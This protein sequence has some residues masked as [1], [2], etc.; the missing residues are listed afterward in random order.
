MT[1]KPDPN[2][3]LPQTA[4][5]TV[6]DVGLRSDHVCISSPNGVY[7]IS[8]DFLSP[9]PP[10]IT[11]EQQAVIEAAAVQGKAFSAHNPYAYS[12]ACFATVSATR[13]MLAAQQPPDPRDAEITML[14]RLLDQVQEWI[15]PAWV[16]S[17]D[18]QTKVALDAIHAAL[19][20][21]G[22]GAVSSAPDP[23][24]ELRE[25]WENFDVDSKK[26]IDRMEA[27]I[28]ALEAKP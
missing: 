3:P 12:A 21:A 6:V 4:M 1:W 2:K 9:L 8:A 7:T 28:A 11:P 23:V 15:R 16:T 22:E 19:K 25:A 27:A 10:G 26:D 14:K 24:R 20:P 17:G 13:A 5:V 18:K